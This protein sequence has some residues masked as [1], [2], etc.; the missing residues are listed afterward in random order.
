MNPLVTLTSMKEVDI[1]LEKDQEYSSDQSGFFTDGYI[2]MGGLY[3]DMPNKARALM[4]LQTL[5]SFDN[6]YNIA[7]QSVHRHDLR[8][9]VV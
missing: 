5:E 3:E 8:L 9:A 7:L 6:Y 1:F 4:V 2:S